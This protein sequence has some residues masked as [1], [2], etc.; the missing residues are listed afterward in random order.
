[1]DVRKAS[2]I[3]WKGTYPV[4]AY[5]IIIALSSVELDSESAGVAGRIREFSAKG[6]GGEADEDGC[7]GASGL[8]EVS[9]AI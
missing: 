4:Q 7:F 6:N 9:F 8:Q 1:M 5:D 3:G 2:K